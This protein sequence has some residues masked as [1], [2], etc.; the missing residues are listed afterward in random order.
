MTAARIGDAFKLD[1]VAVLRET[2]DFAWS[3]RVAAYEVLQS[4]A[5][6]RAAAQKAEAARSKGRSH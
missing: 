6:A 5:K 1:P 2:D 3:V 4:D